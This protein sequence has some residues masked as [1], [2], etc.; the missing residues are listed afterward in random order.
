MDIAPDWRRTPSPEPVDRTP[1]LWWTLTAPVVAIPRL[2][3]PRRHRRWGDTPIGV[4][5]LVTAIIALTVGILATMVG[6]FCVAFITVFGA[7]LD[8]TRPAMAGFAV[9]GSAITAVPFVVALAF[10]FVGVFRRLPP[11]WWVPLAVINGL[12]LLGLGIAALLWFH[13]GTHI[14]W[15][16]S[17]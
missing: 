2:P 4:G 8:V 16:F 14:S 9:R 12:T 1:L 7:P 13:P 6:V 5:A 11:R 3:G 10:F 15:D 17:S